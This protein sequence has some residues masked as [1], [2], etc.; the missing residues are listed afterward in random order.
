MSD[1]S[2][3]FGLGIELR[4][5]DGA[6]SQT[7]TPIPGCGSFSG[8]GQTR[9]T[10][11]TT[12][13]SSTGGYREYI[14]GLRDGGEITFDINWLFGETA[15]D[16]LADSFDDNATVDWQMY[17]PMAVE[18]NLLEFAGFVTNLEWNG[19]IDAQVT[20]SCTIKIT[21]PITVDT[22]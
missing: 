14:S 21:G 11:D 2:A 4:I 12:S 7:F 9:D 13:H 17:F 19:P 3:Y 16:A 8:P 20:R 5:G 6:V 1:P 10:I 15:Q 22:E 18:D